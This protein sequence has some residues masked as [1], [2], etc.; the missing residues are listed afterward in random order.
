VG[1][2][3]P[4]KLPAA[5]VA[6]WDEVLREMI[7]DQAVVAKLRNV[8]FAP[9]YLNANDTRELVRKEMEEAQILWGGK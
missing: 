7:K 9:Y 1:H 8:G 2:H 6:A 5:I 4:P 3:R